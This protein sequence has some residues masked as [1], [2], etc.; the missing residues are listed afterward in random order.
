MRTSICLFFVTILALP[1]V[2][3]AQAQT[4]PSVANE[5]W[6]APAPQPVVPVYPNPWPAAPASQPRNEYGTGYSIVTTEVTRPDYVRQY[7]GE[8]GA[9]TH[10]TVTRV[11]P[12]NAWG[13]PIRPPFGFNYP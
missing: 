11:V 2:A 1:V 6:Y 7:L 8:R 3:V 10:E 9:T 5:P 13:A 4:Y 12:N